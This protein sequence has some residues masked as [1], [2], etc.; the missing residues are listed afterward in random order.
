MKNNNEKM[1]IVLIDSGIDSNREEFRNSEIIHVDMGTFDNYQD[2]EIGHGTAIAFI[3]TKTTNDAKIYSIKLY[4]KNKITTERELIDALTYVYNNIPVDI[5]HISSGVLTLNHKEEFM[6][7]CSLLKKD[8]IIIVSAFANQGIKSY[9]ASFD[10]VVGVYWSAYCTNTNEYI[11]VENS[12]I[13]I[14]AYSG[15]M[16]LPWL[17][18]TY[19]SV[20]GSSFS[21]VYITGII[22]RNM[23]D[24]QIKSSNV[25]DFLKGN[26]K[27]IKH[28]H[29]H[30]DI[31]DYQHI[32]INKV[33]KIKSAIIFPVNKE[34]HAILGNIDL[35]QFKIKDVFDIHYMSNIGK[36]INDI[37]YGKHKLDRVVK[38]YLAI[39]WN[40]DFDTVIL[41]H[42]GV[43]CKMLK[44]DAL[45]YFLDMCYKY[46]KNIYCFDPLTDYVEEVDKIEN[47]GNFVI[48]FKID[49]DIIVDRSFGSLNKLAA[50]V[51]GLFGTSPRQGKFNLQ[52]VLRRKLLKMGYSVGQL[53]TEPSSLLFGM[54]TMIPNGYN[55]CV[56]MSSQQEVYYIN[57][58]LSKLNSKDIIIVAGQSQ[59]VPY[60]FG[61][62]NFYTFHQH[63]LLLASEP[64]AVILSI[65]IGD[66][67][68][69]INR[70]IGYIESY[71]GSKVIAL[72]LYPYR[73]SFDFNVQGS[74]VKEL[75]EQDIVN[76]KKGIQKFFKKIVFLN[77]KEEEMNNLVDLIIEFFS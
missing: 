37:I 54:N 66:N 45:K 38:S 7:I 31:N 77:G 43:I 20:S 52:L 5:I 61:N 33:K 21:S 27:E 41:G 63:N 34:T 49:N 57:N 67:I 12:P 60:S 42:V 39:D 24:K 58:E 65:N 10:D 35:L 28:F 74:I 50:P 56:E 64:D 70:T 11:Y 19:K 25:L 48:S 68:A 46:N 16:R 15:I 47:N 75:K 26:A 23:K 59:T 4:G 55:S 29:E 14:M 3:L 69:Y 22:A 73:K 9:P 17:N 44:F 71:F 53:G 2:D 8:N 76:Y 36:N 72:V 18:G 32:N 13:N 40:D 1:A 51:L 30:N 62:L 6:G